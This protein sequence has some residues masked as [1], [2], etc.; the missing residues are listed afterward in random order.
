[1]NNPRSLLATTLVAGGSMTE[2]EAVLTQMAAPTAAIII[3]GLPTG[4]TSFAD[5]QQLIRLAPAC[6]CCAG[7]LVLTVHLHRLLRQ[8]PPPSALYIVL[9]NAEHLPQLRAQLVNSPYDEHLLLSADY[10]IA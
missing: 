7:N 2:R 1:M 9:H 10:L 8:T 5:T 3:E 6:L 4:Q